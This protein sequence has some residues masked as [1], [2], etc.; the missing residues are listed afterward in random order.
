MDLPRLIDELRRA[1]A[2]PFPLDEVEVRQ[3]HI[4]VVFLAGPFAYKVKK[5]VNLGFLDFSTLERRKHFCH[6]EVRLNR[7]LAPEVYLGVVPVTAGAA[8]LRVEGDGE[9]VEWAV[10]M[11]R[12]PEEATLEKRLQRGE[13]TV[14]LVVALAHKVAHFHGQAAGGAGIAAFGRFQTVARNIWD[15]FGRAL[16]TLGTTI[17]MNVLRRLCQAT[18]Q[19][20]DRWRPLIE[21]RADRG[22]PRD[23]HGDLHLDHVYLFPQR[24]SPGDLVIIDCIEFN[25]RFR[26][27]DPVA[28]MAFLA[29]DLR[30]HGRPDLAQ[31]FAD[32]YFQAS[33]DAE[34]RALLP[35]YTAYRAMVRAKVEAFQLAEKE[36][37]AAQRQQALAQARGHW[38]LALGELSEPPQKPC[39]LLVGGLPGTG[40]ST[41]AQS[42]AKQAGFVLLRSDLLRKELA[43]LPPLEAVPAP[44]RDRV[45]SPPWTEQ[46]YAE[47]LRRAGNL[48]F[49][50]QRVLVDANFRQEEQR[51]PFRILA[52]QL[53]VPWLFFHCHVDP[54]FVQERLVRRRADAS[55]AD[56]GIYQQVATQ[57]ETIELELPRQDWQLD[58]RGTPQDSLEQALAIL[59]A[60][61]LL[62]SCF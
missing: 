10:K 19:T 55:D 7:R 8:G 21:A 61:G 34:G 28:D 20:L 57:W 3:T 15:N 13:V 56:W 59:C 53:G 40:K 30:C 27:T 24:P 58:T 52:R 37:P 14:E 38:L 36:V 4:S 1:A 11:Q 48:L 2:Y 26:C 54:D 31:A 22:M 16:A 17:S 62:V 39:L 5:P 6:E 45:Y 12:L 49:E 29:M 33:G 25:E 46:T 51:R 9:A 18:E 43:G 35:L 42:L 50:G 44:L 23:T 47:C 41:L 60:Q 32:A